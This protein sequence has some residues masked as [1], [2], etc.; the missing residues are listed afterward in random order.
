MDYHWDYLTTG[1]SSMPKTL[2]EL[3]EENKAAEEQAKLD[4]EKKAKEALEDDKDADDKDADKDDGSDDK[5]ADGADADDGSDDK[6]ADA[7]KD[8]DTEPW[9][10]VDDR[11]AKKDKDFVPVDAH[12]ELKKQLQGRISKKDDE[13]EKLKAENEALR[14]SQKQE[15]K[16]RPN[17]DDFTDQAEFDKALLVY[18]DWEFEDHTRR[19]RIKD[20]QRAN[21]ITA[22]RVLGENLDKHYDRAATLLSKSG[23]APELFKHADSKVRKAVETLRPGLGDVIIDNLISTLGE[24]SE[25]VMYYLGVNEIALNKFQSLLIKDPL[26]LQAAVFLGQEKQRLTITTKRRSNAPAPA[27][28]ADGDVA[29]GSEKSLKRRYAAA[30]SPQEAYDIKQKAKK[31]GTDTKNW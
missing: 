14:A 16:V 24:G 30:K 17:P 2:E 22:N 19:V 7:D 11:D 8:V 6:D 23:I 4:S 18:E 3:K 9:M 10:D 21:Q 15:P 13:L 26:G 27:R 20:D 29:K 31:A 25:K 28:K 1:E 5:D 12:V